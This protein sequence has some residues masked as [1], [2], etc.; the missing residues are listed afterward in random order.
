[1]RPTVT[2][3]F[4]LFISYYIL[5][6]IFRFLFLLQLTNAIPLFHSHVLAPTA[7]MALSL[8]DSYC[9]TQQLVVTG[10]YYI[11]SETIPDAKSSISFDQST[12]SD[13]TIYFMFERIHNQL[14][15]NFGVIPMLILSNSALKKAAEE[16]DVSS[17]LFSVRLSQITL[18]NSNSNLVEIVPLP[19]VLEATILKQ[20]DVSMNG[21]PYENQL[22]H[23]L[24]NLSYIPR[25]Y[26]RNLSPLVKQNKFSELIDV[27][28]Y[29][30]L[31][32]ASG[33]A[34]CLSNGLVEND[35]NNLEKTLSE[36]IQVESKKN[37]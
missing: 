1:M 20:A 34:D 32:S 33:F 7:E 35:I 24:S 28:D 31:G 36:P 10:T 17:P 22:I 16:N 18:D 15:V 30:D 25:H 27:D 37:V 21:T 11:P 19:R 14:S 8:V 23:S 26:L 2:P 6:S 4:Y 3:S 29:L 13:T 5:I 9:A 12:I